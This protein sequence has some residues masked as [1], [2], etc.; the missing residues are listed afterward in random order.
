[1]G[2]CASAP[3]DIKADA[4]AAPLP[5]QPKE[6]ETTTTTTVT[7]EVTTVDKQVNGEDGEKKVDD[8]KVAADIDNS[9]SLGSLLTENEAAKESVKDEKSSETTDKKPEEAKVS[10]ETDAKQP[11]GE[12][13]ST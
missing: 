5:E 8:E 13:K 12:E 9:N 1:M 11:A 7:T 4:A 2:A 3:K 6:E 10:D